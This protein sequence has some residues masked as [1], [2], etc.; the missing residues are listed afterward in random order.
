M[1]NKKMN[2]T[3]MME[4]GIFEIIATNPLKEFTMPGIKSELLTAYGI[5]VIHQSVWSVV[6][7]LEKMNLV[8]Q[9]S[10]V[11]NVIHYSI[12]SR[13]KISEMIDQ[14]VGF[15]KTKK[16]NVIE[17][18]IVEDTEEEV[19]VLLDFVEEENYNKII[20][21]LKKYD[22]ET[23]DDMVFVV[24]AI[25]G[26]CIVRKTTTFNSNNIFRLVNFLPKMKILTILQTLA[27]KKCVVKPEQTDEGTVAYRVNVKPVDF[28]LNI[29]NGV[30]CHFIKTEKIEEVE[31][32]AEKIAGVAL[33]N[34]QIGL[35]VI[36]WIKKAETEREELMAR[37]LELVK[38]N[39]QLLDD[40]FKM[41]EELHKIKNEFVLLSSNHD[42]LVKSAAGTNS[43]ITLRSMSGEHKK[44]VGL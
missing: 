37:M 12:V 8:S 30:L 6:K 24:L 11:S 2:K 34:E 22:I 23:S 33:S 39:G 28:G 36:D 27:N 7:R 9:I 25:M 1:G 15:P 19:N 42:K 4:N 43:K 16:E 13:V 14:K 32:H 20:K 35:G 5:D 44:R 10:S 31:S 21:R 29:T 40:N 17:N 41:E 18:V 26:H 38:E 3:I